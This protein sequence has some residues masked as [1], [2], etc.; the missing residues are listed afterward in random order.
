MSYL[1]LCRGND[2]VLPPLGLSGLSGL[3]DFHKY[4]QISIYT[5]YR[6]YN[7]F[8]FQK[9]K[10]D[11]PR[12]THKPLTYMIIKKIIIYVKILTSQSHD[13]TMTQEN[14]PVINP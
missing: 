4:S 2:R 9:S 6:Y 12:P 5:I 3:T 13:F 10:R 11:R 1:I 7:F 8:F 14:D